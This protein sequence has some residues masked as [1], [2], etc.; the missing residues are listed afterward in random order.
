MHFKLVQSTS[1]HNSGSSVASLA[2]AAAA[3]AAATAAQ[4]APNYSSESSA[5]TSPGGVVSAVGTPSIFVGDWSA[6]VQP[7]ETTATRMRP[8]AGGSSARSNDA[9]SAQSQQQQQQ[10]QQQQYSYSNDYDMLD[11]DDDEE[12]D[13]DEDG[14]EYDAQNGGTS[15][16]PGIPVTSSTAAGPSSL[17]GLHQQR[18]ADAQSHAGGS[19]GAAA[20]SSSGGADTPPKK[21]QTR[22][23]RACTVCRKLKM[24]CVGAEDPPCKRCRNGGHQCIFEES[25]R[26]RRSNRK[27]DMM[28]KSLKRLESTLETVLKSISNPGALASSAGL[29]SD[30]NV[31][32]LVQNALG[33]LE[34]LSAD[35]PL[36]ESPVHLASSAAATA[37][38]PTLTATAPDDQPIQLHSSVLPSLR[39]GARYE[40]GGGAIASPDA[41]ASSSS[42]PQRANS[43]GSG[44]GQQQQASNGKSVEWSGVRNE[45]TRRDDSPRLHSLP[46]NTL[47]P[48]GLLAEASLQ[49][50]RKRAVTLNDVLETANGLRDTDEREMKRSRLGMGN[51]SYFQPG[52]MNILPLRRIVFEQRMP[53]ALLEEKILSV[54]EVVE[55]FSIYFEHCHRHAPFLDPEIHTPATTGSRS[56]FLFTCICTVAARF[57]TKRTDDLYRKCLRIA[58]KIAFDAMTKGY[59][60]TEICQG[61]LLLCGWN[62]PAERFEEERTYQFSGIAIRM[63]TDLNLHRKTLTVLPD[64]VSAETKTLYQREIMNRERTWI[65]CYICDRSTSTQMG[66]PFSIP[67]EDFIL[68]SARTWY[69][70]SGASRRTD[71]GLCGMVEMHRIVGRMIDTLYSDTRSV[72]GLNTNLDYNILMR[73]FLSQLDQWR[74]DWTELHVLEGQV[75]TGRKRGAQNG[76]KAVGPMTEQTTMYIDFAREMAHFYHAY[77]RLFLLSFAVQEG[78]ERPDKG[79]DLP[80]YCVLCFESASTMIGIARD[81]LGPNG[82]LRYSLD[83][84]FVYLSYAA[85]FLLKLISPTFAHVIDENAAIRLVRDVAETFERSAVDENHTPALYASFLKTLIDNKLHGPR[86]APGS[87]ANTRPGSPVAGHSSTSN[88]LPP[89]G[90]GNENMEALLKMGGG[91]LHHQQMF[92][93]GVPATSGGGGELPVGEQAFDSM[94]MDTMLSNGGFWD[95]MLMPGFGGPLA[96]LS[97]GTG[98]ML[99]NI[100]DPWSVTPLH[101]RPGSPTGTS[102]HHHPAFPTFDFGV[103]PST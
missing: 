44:A 81:F 30:P 70:E 96:S 88:G 41:A 53:P 85:T 28:A 8:S 45:R 92:E 11:D 103:P 100:T 58:K 34:G 74:E 48:L 64:D 14:S 25:Q 42:A 80:S 76:S 59:K 91:D 46:D 12:E 36:S 93:G 26:G 89:A 18:L 71:G 84:T 68:R 73:A 4:P 22:G 2:A 75:E 94:A 37:G 62:Q 63:A 19:S 82:M 95:N 102:H 72:S 20:G 79:I 55:L 31:R 23:S 47:N 98:T 33:G 29:L 60:S 56:P 7:A 43:T 97:G 10:Q 65:Y 99:G 78:R 38:G 5:A 15:S 6:A 39:D 86:T 54:E 24:R 17:A 13:E 57:Y 51:P 35:G 61:F 21:K 3:A 83:S 52:P 87:R 9:Y 32:P 49:N 77:Y 67:K 40:I 69:K 50:T 66:K 90:P 27:T 101:S 1:S 16:L